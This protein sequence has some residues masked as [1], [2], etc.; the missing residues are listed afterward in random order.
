MGK[1]ISPIIA[2][3]YKAIGVDGHGVSAEV[4]ET[5]QSQQEIWEHSINAGTLKGLNKHNTIGSLLNAGIVSYFNETY[6]QNLL[7]SRVNDIVYYRQP[8]F[9]TFGLSLS[10]SYFFGI[11]KSVEYSGV[12]MDVDRLAENSE[13][14][15][16]CWN[17]WVQFNRDTGAIS[18]LYENIIPESLFSTE[19]RVLEGVSATKLIAKG[20]LLGQKVYTLT[21]EN[22]SSIN[23]INLDVDTRREILNAIQ[24]GQ[25]VT[26]HAEKL[27]VGNW[28]GFGYFKIDPNTGAGGYIIS[29]GA[30]G[31]E[32]SDDFMSKFLGFF[33]TYGI[34]LSAGEAAGLLLFGSIPKS[35]VGEKALLGSNN[36][37]TSALRG[38]KVSFAKT[39][40]M[41]A[42]IVP[43]VTTVGIFIGFYNVTIAL[44][45]LIYAI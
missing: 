16:N 21:K 11:P 6:K 36:P 44:Q 26:I 22:A 29:G 10:V 14:K 31:G 39:V 24:T 35:W 17:D 3:E 18:S 12:G 15:S 45:A 13:S 30:N 25:E 27:T 41:R 8:S 9:G 28:N 33:S 23:E 7:T 2:G 1:K 40:I 5:L 42:A 37:L 20:Q 34:Q 19:G 32:I 43:L 38:L 4:L